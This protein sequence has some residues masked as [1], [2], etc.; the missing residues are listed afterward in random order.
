MAEARLCR[1]EG[2]M[3]DFVS[4]IKDEAVSKTATRF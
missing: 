1:D 4:D 2:G 3:L